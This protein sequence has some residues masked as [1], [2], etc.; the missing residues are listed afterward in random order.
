MEVYLQQKSF[1]FKPGMLFLHYILG[2]NCLIHKECEGGSE[3]CVYM[4]S[5]QD[6]TWLNSLSSCG[7]KDSVKNAMA[8]ECS[9]CQTL[10]NKDKIQQCQNP[11]GL[12]GQEIILFRHGK[13]NNDRLPWS[14]QRATTLVSPAKY[15]QQHKYIEIKH[16]KIYLLLKFYLK[17]KISKGFLYSKWPYS[18]LRNNLL[19]YLLRAY[20]MS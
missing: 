18:C 6:F 4:I 9:V 12:F 8:A 15:S 19:P 11:D 10:L 14:H 5:E 20:C 16:H 2:N 13:Q 7:L 1:N 3:C 17:S